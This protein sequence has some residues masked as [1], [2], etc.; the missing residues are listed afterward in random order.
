MNITIDELLQVLQIAIGPVILISGA[1]LLLLSM[2][3]RLGR[4]VDRA[5]LLRRE[6]EDIST[7][8]KEA[9]FLQLAILRSRARL[10]RRSIIFASFSILLA[11][12]LVI[13]LF[14]AALLH[15]NNP[16]PPTILFTACM[17]SLI[18]ALTDFIRDVN[19]TL[20]ALDV[21]L[22]KV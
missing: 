22:G 12:I 14:I 20:R 19:Q 18:I 17:L 8:E 1:G 10:L 3:N 21:E 13:M 2:T 7:T 15:W 11:A 5:R 4:V 6:L 16:F 9:N